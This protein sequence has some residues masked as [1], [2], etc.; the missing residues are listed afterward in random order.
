MLAGLG[1]VPGL[2]L[3][4]GSA[5]FGYGM[6]YATADRFSA[7]R[8]TL[9][10]AGYAIGAAQMSATSKLGPIGW[11]INAAMIAGAFLPEG[12]AKEAISGAS[13]YLMGE[14]AGDYFVKMHERVKSATRGDFGGQKVTMNERLMRSQ[15]QA[16]SMLRQSRGVTMMGREAA[17]MHN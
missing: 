10:S 6:E 11:G 5:A 8:G 12:A 3:L 4:A 17:L 14:A 16:L 7:E 1:K 13:Y 9:K 15:N 2:P